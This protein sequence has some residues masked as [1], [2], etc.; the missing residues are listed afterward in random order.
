MMSQLIDKINTIEVLGIDGSGKTSVCKTVANL[1]EFK[2]QLIFLNGFEKREFSNE[3]D[4]IL[5]GINKDRNEVFSDKFIN[6]LW[7]SDLINTTFST[8]IPTLNS[9]KKVILDRYLLSAKVYSI[10]T[11][12][13][14]ISYLFDIYNILPQPEL[15]IYLKVEPEIAFKRILKRGSTRTYYENISG[16]Q[17]IKSTYEDYLG[18]MNNVKVI[19]ANDDFDKVISNIKS[20]LL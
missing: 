10:A 15:Y 18:K 1:S 3:I 16:L 4:L 6:M 17:K 13:S 9:G 2:K 5:K 14:D 7:M 19:D 12:S 8:I 20:I 11:T